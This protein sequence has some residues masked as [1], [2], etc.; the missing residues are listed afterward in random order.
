MDEAAEQ[1]CCY[2]RKQAAHPAYN[3]WC[4]DCYAD[5]RLTKMYGRRAKDRSVRN[6]PNP[7]RGVDI[8]PPVDPFLGK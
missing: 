7:V 6:S 4:E 1:K 5:V 3:D 2:C 8:L